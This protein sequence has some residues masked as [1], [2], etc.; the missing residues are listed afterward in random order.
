MPDPEPVS[1][2]LP[3]SLPDGNGASAVEPA[4]ELAA[5]VA[6]IR[7][8]NR[9]YTAHVGALSERLLASPFSLAE[10]R[11]LYELGQRD[12]LTAA[13]LG[14]DL[15]LDAAYLSR[16]LR[17]F[18]Q[19]GL[20]ARRPDPA[21][22][23]GRLLG[24][25]AAGRDAF[26][27][28]DAASRDWLGGVLGAL[29]PDRRR[30]LAA[31]MGAIRTILGDPVAPERTGAPTAAPVVIG[32]ARM[33]DVSW[34]AH[35]QAVIYRDAYGWNARFEAMVTEI[36][37]A[38]LKAHDGAREHCWVAGQGGAILGAVFL[39]RVDDGL[40]KL[41]MLYVEPTARGLGLGRRLAETCLDFARAAGYRRITL[42]T[43][44]CL[45]EARGLYDSLGFA[46]VSEHPHSEFGP[47]M[48]GQV[49]ERDL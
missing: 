19:A 29:A 24:L 30:A 4:G 49:L 7:A 20:V 27:G 42:W 38:F 1:D 32:S 6:D 16:I 12:G 10:A 17:R 43:N 2:S 40:A 46:L 47:H 35:R 34:A 37:G 13:V 3:D 18:A 48:V 28:L 11:V 39:V 15:D 26:A 21:D 44:D 5:L 9:F 31:A 25:T 14:R 33:G 8:F 41:R 23:R 22:G 36:A 45:I